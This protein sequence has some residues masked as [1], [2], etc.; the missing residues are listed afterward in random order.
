MRIG[1]AVVVYNR[2]EHTK[3]M[4]DALV[5]ADN[6]KL[7][8]VFIFSDAA[9]DSSKV[10]VSE[11][12]NYIH[13]FSINYSN[14]KIIEANENLGCKGNVRFSID[15]VLNRYDAVIVIED[16][17]VISQSFLDYMK[18]LLE[19]YK[20]E[21]KVGEIAGYKYPDILFSIPRSYKYDIF[22]MNRTSSWG[23]GT[24]KDRWTGIDWELNDIKNFKDSPQKQSMFNEGGEDLSDMLINEG[25]WDLIWAY[26]NFKN[27][28]LTVYPTKSYVENVGLDGTGVHCAGGNE[29]IW[30]IGKLNNS[31][32]NNYPTNVGIDRGVQKQFQNIFKKGIYGKI[33]GL[34]KK[35]YKIFKFL[36]Y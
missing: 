30:R 16:D 2:L 11:V 31:L 35:F 1:I 32:P 14:I 21:S 33:R 9:R 29:L 20:T 25:E 36:F 23:W 28:R 12:R 27:N 7:Y 19:K 18:L 17:V 4:L 6:F 24:W 26:H 15:Y 34:K 22:F 8:D 3:K 13:E 5:Q 10:S